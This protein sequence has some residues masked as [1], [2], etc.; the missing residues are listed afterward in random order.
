MVRRDF[1]DLDRA[2]EEGGVLHT[3]NRLTTVQS[4]SLQ[5]RHDLL[6]ECS[7]ADIQEMEDATLSVLHALAGAQ[8]PARCGGPL[9]ELQEAQKGA[10]WLCRSS[11]FMAVMTVMAVLLSLSSCRPLEHVYTLQTSGPDG[12]C[13]V[14]HVSA[15]VAWQ[16]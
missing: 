10:L 11:L 15:S 7:E 8:P 12:G 2:V 6:A 13:S 5:H 14:E 1:D 3:S 16:S 9:H 4:W